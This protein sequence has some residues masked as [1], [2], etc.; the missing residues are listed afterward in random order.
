MG[1]FGDIDSAFTRDELKGGTFEPTYSGAVSFMRRK[2]SRDL[3]GVDVAVTGIPFDTATT[4][5]PGTRFGPRHIRAESSHI[6]WGPPYN[7]DY[8]PFDRLAV[9]D[10]GDCH[11]DHGKPASIPGA[12]E[13]HIAGILNAG[14]ATLTL[15]GDHY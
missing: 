8:E 7:W 9:V 13:D 3:T 5:R 10:Y 14:A 11:F 6:A 15:G 2:Y 4:N 12:I 1:N